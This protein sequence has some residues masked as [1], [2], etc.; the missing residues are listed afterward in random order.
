MRTAIVIGATGLVGRQLVELLLI[1]SRF[2]LVKIFTRRST[3]LSHKKLEEHVVDFDDVL[4]WKKLVTGD[5][6]YSAMG[7]TLR[8]AGNKENQYK[9]DYHYQYQVARA[10][11][12][13]EVKEY[14]LVSSAG[15]D[16]G[17]KIFYSRMKGELER[18]VKKLPFAAVH[19]IRPGILSGARYEVRVGEKIGIGIMRVLSVIPGLG[20][21]K[22]IEG[23]QVAKAMINATF[24]HVIGIHA[25]TMGEVFKLANRAN[26]LAVPGRS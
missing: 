2:G 21:L 26:V 25:Y 24:R 17:S 15:A 20:N 10:A 14:V 16:P 12:G 22:P 23:I 7:T 5:V 18:D 9:V 3:G 8:K 11:A 13:N 6:L 19:I 1:D 4:N